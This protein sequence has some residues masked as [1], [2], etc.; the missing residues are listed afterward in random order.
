MMPGSG[1][2]AKLSVASRARQ[3]KVHYNELRVL[4]AAVW[5]QTLLVTLSLLAP[6]VP[7]WLAGWMTGPGERLRI[8]A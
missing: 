3:S 4:K 1:L 6:L 7:A 8:A 5:R 2:G